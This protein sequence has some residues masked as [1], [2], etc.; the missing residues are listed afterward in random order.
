MRAGR[1]ALATEG[2]VGVVD[3]RREL[4]GSE[5]VEGAETGVEFS[6]GDAALAIE[7][8]EKMGG[9]SLPFQGIAFEARRK[10][11]GKCKKKSRSELWRG[12]VG[13]YLEPATPAG[14]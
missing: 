3:G 6:G 7:P 9:R 12:S 13:R 11:R 8:A 2:G 10:P 14:T 1:A 5:G 4:A